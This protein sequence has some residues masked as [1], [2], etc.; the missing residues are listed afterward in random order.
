MQIMM[1]R[2]ARS[3]AVKAAMV[4]AVLS[5]SA[6]IAHATGGDATFDGMVNKIDGWLT[7]SLGILLGLGGLIVTIA[8]LMRQQYGGAAIGIVVALAGATGPAVIKGI[9]PVIM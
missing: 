2:V 8:S 7:G 5:T 1:K 9:F 4:V 6:G 3:R